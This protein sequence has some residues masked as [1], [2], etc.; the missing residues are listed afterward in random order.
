MRHIHANEQGPSLPPGR[1]AQ[2]VLQRRRGPP[3]VDWRGPEVPAVQPGG[4]REA[5]RQLRIGRVASKSE[6]QRGRKP[7]RA[8]CGPF[9]DRTAFRRGQ[10]GRP[11]GPQGRRVGDPRQREPSL[12][13]P[14]P[15][16]PGRRWGV[17]GPGRGSTR[18]D[19]RFGPGDFRLRTAPEKAPAR[20]RD[21]HRG[22]WRAGAAL[23]GW[24]RVDA[25][26]V[27]ETRRARSWASCGVGGAPSRPDP[28]A[29]AGGCARE[30][31]QRG[32]CHIHANEQGPSLPPGRPAQ[33]F[34]HRRR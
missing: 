34:H 32:L 6:R 12:P 23:A 8:A 22:R 27:R 4:A 15:R 24:G 1:P 26:A 29:A 3:E 20:W 17:A 25:E 21:G 10:R 28:P 13:R 30:D 9:V 11:D 31:T 5:E 33:T 19:Q 14:S 18:S 16:Q 2:A 7:R